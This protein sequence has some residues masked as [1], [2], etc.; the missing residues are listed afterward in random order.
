[1]NNLVSLDIKC[2]S[3][4]RT[5]IMDFFRRT[6]GFGRNCLVLKESHPDFHKSILKAAK[7]L[8][9]LKDFRFPY[10]KNVFTETTTFEK[11]RNNHPCI[12]RLEIYACK[13]LVSITYIK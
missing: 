9:C 2:D 6:D 1:M 13:R 7:N 11:I 5:R 3:K 8:R 10:S 4:E 12:E